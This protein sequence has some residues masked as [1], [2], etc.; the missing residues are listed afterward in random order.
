LQCARPGAFIDRARRLQVGER[1][2]L[3]EVLSGPLHYD[4]AWEARP[5]WLLASG[6]GLTP[7]WAVLQ[8]ALRLG[9]LG[10]IQVVHLAAPG[11]HYLADELEALAALHPGLHT[12][13]LGPGAD[14]SPLRP[15]RQ[16]IALACGSPEAV[17][18]IARRLFMAGLP[19]SQVFHEVFEA[20]PG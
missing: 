20:G 2:R 7:L 14:L 5:L 15:P 4:P 13:L 12:Q 9:H 17:Q 11:E 10:P 6:T 16:A 19:R 18:A 8:E 3:G 1:L